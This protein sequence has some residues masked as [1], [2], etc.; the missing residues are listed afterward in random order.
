MFTGVG[1][2]KAKTPLD[3]MRC[4][5]CDYLRE[6][7]RREEILAAVERALDR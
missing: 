5:A 4:G 3:A 2:W 6:P 1:S 7:A